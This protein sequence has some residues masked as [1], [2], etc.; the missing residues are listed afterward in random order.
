MSSC[1][2]DELLW[3]DLHVDLSHLI[4]I[5]IFYFLLAYEKL[6]LQSVQLNL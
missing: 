6:F 5:L 3:P 2:V 1:V 4:S